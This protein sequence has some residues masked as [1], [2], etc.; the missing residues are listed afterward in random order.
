MQRSYRS[1]QL[2]SVRKFKTTS[3][4]MSLK[5]HDIIIAEITSF[6]GR[7]QPVSY[8]ADDVI[9]AYPLKSNDIHQ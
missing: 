8:D 5:F 6:S 2:H 9:N 3:A 1:I 4:R 7:C